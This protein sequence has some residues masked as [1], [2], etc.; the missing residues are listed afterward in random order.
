M[1][2]SKSFPIKQAR[3]FDHYL[4]AVENFWTGNVNFNFVFSN[5]VKIDLVADKPMKECKIQPGRDV[6]RIV[7]WFNP[8]NA[9]LTSIQLFDKFG[10][11]L[12]NMGM[13]EEERKNANHKTYE[14][15][16][17]DGERI[18]GFKSRRKCAKQAIHFD[19][20]FLIGNM[21]LF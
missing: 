11:K 4:I 21:W 6:K 18:I 17:E 5:G 9:V 15:Q 2:I 7:L 8:V 12:I 19:F 10:L 3:S 1:P 20:K 14:T 13:P 16:L